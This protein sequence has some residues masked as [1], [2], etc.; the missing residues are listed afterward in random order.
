MSLK[1]LGIWE[2]YENIVGIVTLVIG[3][4]IYGKVFCEF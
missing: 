2:C 1:S 3:C 4:I